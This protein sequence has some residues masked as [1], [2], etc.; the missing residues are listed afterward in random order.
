MMW[1]VPFNA[2]SSPSSRNKMVSMGGKCGRIEVWAM[3]YCDR[4]SRSNVGHHWEEK[5]RCRIFKIQN[6]LISNSLFWHRCKVLNLLHRRKTALV[7]TG[8][9]IRQAL[10]WQKALNAW[11]RLLS[12]NRTAKEDRLASLTPTLENVIR[13]SISVDQIMDEK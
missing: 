7:V 5:R 10:N 9:F 6:W 13:Y 8:L 3:V 4:K 1:L 12:R 2:N 11:E